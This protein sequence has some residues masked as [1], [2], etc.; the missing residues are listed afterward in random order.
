MK[1]S[2]A[3]DADL[4]SPRPMGR[5]VRTILAGGLMAGAAALVIL[6]GNA[7]SLD[8]DQ[9]V[10]DPDEDPAPL[11]SIAPPEHASHPIS[12]AAE[13][14]Q[15]GAPVTPGAA[16]HRNRAP[17]PLQVAL[18]AI[19]D[20]VEPAAEAADSD[21]G[22]APGMLVPATF[23]VGDDGG[24][25]AKASFNGDD[26]FGDMGGS[27]MFAPPSA[28]GGGFLKNPQA[29]TGANG[30][31]TGDPPLG[32]GPVL[33]ALSVAGPVPEPS[34]WILLT[35]GLAGIGGAMRRHRH[36]A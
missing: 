25:F 14:S 16:I 8:Y 13:G 28:G 20:S 23:Q 18:K 12:F 17:A 36:A 21:D 9:I 3:L 31:P 33:A 11:T 32:L 4:Q 27:G 34:T 22:D 6:V 35:L 24:G 15:A 26:S 10:L 7:V 30:Q 19:R 2:I 5:T 29:A 1:T